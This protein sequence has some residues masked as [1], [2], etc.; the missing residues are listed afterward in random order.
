MRRIAGDR[1]WNLAGHFG[2]EEFAAA[3]DMAALAVTNNTG[4]VHLAAAL[5]TA[6]VDLYALTN[7]QHTPW[8]VAHRLLSHDVPCRNCYKSACPE[9]HHQCLLGVTVAQAV[10]A[11][12]DLWLDIHWRAAA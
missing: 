2:L 11:A 5:Q 3:L 12:C 6:V 10:A 8:K 4:T 9:S 7:P 1:A